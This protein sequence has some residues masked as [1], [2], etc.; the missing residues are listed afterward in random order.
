MSNYHFFYFSQIYNIQQL[1]EEETLVEV[2]ESILCLIRAAEHF[3]IDQRAKTEALIRKMERAFL[4]SGEE[5]NRL[6]I[7]DMKN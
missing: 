4:I 3:A 5:L 7:L 1:I 6:I 2:C